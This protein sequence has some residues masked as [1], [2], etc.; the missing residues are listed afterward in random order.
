[1]AETHTRGR[2]IDF[3][4]LFSCGH[5]LISTLTHVFEGIHVF[6]CDVYVGFPMYVFSFSTHTLLISKLAFAHLNVNVI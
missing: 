3:H 4:V 1:M 2:N 6:C 5:R